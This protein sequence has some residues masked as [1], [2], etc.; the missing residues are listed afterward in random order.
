[1]PRLSRSAS[2]WSLGS[3]SPHYRLQIC[4]LRV[5]KTNFISFVFNTGLVHRV[6][7]SYIYKNG[8]MNVHY[9]LGLSTPTVL[10]GEQGSPGKLTST[11]QAQRSQRR[12]I[13]PVQTGPVILNG[14]CLLEF[15]IGFPSALEHE[16][17]SP[18][19]IRA[20]RMTFRHGFTVKMAST[21][22]NP[23]TWFGTVGS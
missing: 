1:M 4:Y 8:Q 15:M 10:S 9:M 19:R 13:S 6:S 12:V 18:T 14:K 17:R 3:T 20:R 23:P 21:K 22:R 5:P 11:T 2:V 16:V 7:E